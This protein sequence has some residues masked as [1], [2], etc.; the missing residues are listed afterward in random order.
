M[1]INE[2]LEKLNMTKY[3]L[4]MESGVPQATI[5]DICSGKAKLEKCAAGTLFRLAKTLGV[6]ME[7][8]LQSAE[9]DSEQRSGFETF[10]SSVC[11]QVKEMGD[12]AFMLHLLE[13]DEIRT[14]YAKGWYPEAM[15][16]LAMLDYLSRVNQIP[17]CTRYDDIRTQ[18]LK[19]PLYSTGVLVAGEV[20]KSDKPLRMAEQNAIPE[21]SRFNI[22]ES[23]VRDVV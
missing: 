22:M 8:I 10:K 2:R 16:M 23:E 17:L 1:L 19:K 14:L 20:L 11:H 15:Y 4:S 6:T 21:F 13:S 18:K 5:H 3:R 9:M 7:E 12:V